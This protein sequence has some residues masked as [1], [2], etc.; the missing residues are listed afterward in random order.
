MPPKGFLGSLDFPYRNI[1]HVFTRRKM[2]KTY[3]TQELIPFYTP[4]S[5]TK[6][7]EEPNKL[8]QA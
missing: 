8:S 6:I 5:P 3:A 2:L 7:R 1:C 4:K